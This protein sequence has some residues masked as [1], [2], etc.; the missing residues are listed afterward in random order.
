M[1]KQ[2]FDYTDNVECQAIVL[3]TQDIVN[4]SILISELKDIHFRN[5][6]S[7]RH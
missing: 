7:A 3:A 2:E 6:H 4:A 1:T 5:K